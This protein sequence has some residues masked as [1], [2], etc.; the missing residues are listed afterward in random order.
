MAEQD[1]TLV[2]RAQRGDRDAFETLVRRHLRAVHAAAL[3]RVDDPEDA[4]DV[5]QDVFLTA[6][7][8]IRECREPAKFRSWVLAIA[9]NRAHNV[10]AFQAVRRPND[11]SDPEELVGHEA[12]PVLTAARTELRGHLAVA[13]R[14]LTR[15]QREVLLMHDM[16]GWK[17]KEIAEKLGISTAASRFH[18][19]VAR[20][21]VRTRL[22]GLYSGEAL[23]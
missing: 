19:F 17:H 6:L 10:R 13:I 1:A 7:H 23:P 18:L 3:A 12:S 4:D 21:A 9:R 8:R 14:T 2:A 22:G 16:E 15:L 11:W 5:V 20:R